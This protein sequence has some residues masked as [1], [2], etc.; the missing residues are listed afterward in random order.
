MPT[1]SDRNSIAPEP[2][3]SAS[4]PKL[5]RI[6]AIGL[7]V[8]IGY[9][10]VQALISPPPPIDQQKL[11][12]KIEHEGQEGERHHKEQMTSIED[13][14]LE[15]ASQKGVR[16]EVLA[17]LFVARLHEYE[18]AGIEA[19]MLQHHLFGDFDTLELIG[20]EVIPALA[21]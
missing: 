4:L 11:E 12:Q 18:A 1:P 6:A 19:V 15:I 10:G 17:P 8:L 14:R 2:K 5:I 16:P 7:V 3:L 20:R 13:L 9:K 21:G